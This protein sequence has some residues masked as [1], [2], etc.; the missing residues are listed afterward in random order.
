[1]QSMSN[2]M[3]AVTTAAGKLHDLATQ[4]F[5][6]VCCNCCGVVDVVCAYLLIYFVLILIL[7][8]FVRVAVV[9]VVVVAVVLC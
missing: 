7:S 3:N 2:T 8:L 4:Q 9:I 5:Q 6:V 1:M